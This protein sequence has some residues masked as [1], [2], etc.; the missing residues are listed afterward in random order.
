MPRKSTVGNDINETVGEKWLPKADDDRGEMPGRI[1]ARG[2]RA[3]DHPLA[4]AYKMARQASPRAFGSPMPDYILHYGFPKTGSTAIQRALSEH[5]ADPRFVYSHFQDPIHDHGNHS[6]AMAT[7]FS[8]RPE[9]YHTHVAEGLSAEMLLQERSTLLGRLDEEITALAGRTFLLSNES[10]SFLRAKGLQR[11]RRFLED[12][13]LAPRPVGYVRPL[14]ENFEGLFV[15]R[16]KHRQ[17][18]LDDFFAGRAIG[19]HAQIATLD[20]VFGRENVLLWKYDRRSFS[21]GCV[22]ADFC[23]RL[24]IDRPPVVDR[25][26]NRSLSLP[27]VR[28]LFAYRHFFPASP[29]GRRTIEHNSA[30]IAALGEI[31]GPRFRFHPLLL[32]PVIREQGIHLDWLEARVGA[33]LR[34]RMDDDGGPSIRSEEDLLDFSRE[35]LDWLARRTG[36]AAGSLT[37]KDPRAVADAVDRLRE[38]AVAERVAAERKAAGLLAR[39]GHR[40]RKLLGHF[41]RRSR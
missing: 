18:S 12:R 9:E 30:L 15:E 20:K 5:L 40:S 33:T 26:A 16:L 34:D 7:A 36:C 8:D 41:G 29:P 2:E 32:E 24:G 23:L 6:R 39:L 37:G 17:G 38:I 3:R 4:V 14:R 35:S 25:E 10:L 27:A 22:V 28:F 11:L 31:D 21:D 1:L 13:H 19:P